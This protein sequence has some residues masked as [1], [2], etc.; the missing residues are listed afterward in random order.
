MKQLP[1]VRGAVAAIEAGECVVVYPEGTITKDP[2]LWPMVG[3]TGAARIALAT[4]SSAYT[5][6][7]VG[8]V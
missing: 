6:C 5:G 2:G 3:K 8:S 7:S 4:G 1:P